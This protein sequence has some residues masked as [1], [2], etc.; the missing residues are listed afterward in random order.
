MSCFNSSLVLFKS[1]TCLLINIDCSI[2]CL[3]FCCKVVRGLNDLR[4]LCRL[5]IGKCGMSC[6]NR[7]L[8]LCKSSIYWLDLND[9]SI[10]CLLFCG[11]VGSGLND[12]RMLCQLNLGKC[13]MSC[14]KRSLPTFKSSYFSIC[15]YTMGH[16]LINHM[17][18]S[19]S[20]TSKFCVVI[21]KSDN[22]SCLIC[23]DRARIFKAIV[24]KEFAC[25]NLFFISWHFENLAISPDDSWAIICLIHGK[26]T[27]SIVDTF[28]SYL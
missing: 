9:V 2:C 19:S 4:M 6:F 1:N 16:A 28:C 23:C 21:L 22:F 5:N 24:C 18:I 17:I 12:L 15:C 14:Y 7:S 20:V 26:S 10:R 25:H 13:G 8:V 3:L 27:F 11:K